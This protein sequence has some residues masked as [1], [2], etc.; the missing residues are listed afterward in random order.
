[1]V[2]DEAHRCLKNYAYT[3]V[4]NYYKQQAQ[5]QRILGLTASP[6]SEISK[7]KEICKHL[8]IDT[9]EVRTRESPDVKP[10]LQDLE[11]NKIEVPFPQEFIEIRTLLKT[12]Y[13]KKVTQLRNMNLLFGPA[14][15][16]SLLNL[17]KKLFSRA[18]Q[19]G[20]NI[21]AGVSI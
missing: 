6:G 12:I 14:N 17:Q 2:I 21:F 19:T 9:M 13:E 5:N 11:F 20:G 10:Y 3:S 15:K 18:V 7:I 4:V 1:M 16:I 8:D